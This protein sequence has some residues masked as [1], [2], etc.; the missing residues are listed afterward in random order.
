MSV[1]KFNISP[2]EGNLPIRLN[3]WVPLVETLDDLLSVGKWTGSLSVMFYPENDGYLHVVALSEKPSV[4]LDEATLTTI[5]F[6]EKLS[7]KTC[8]Q[9]GKRGWERSLHYFGTTQFVTLCNGCESEM[10][11][12]ICDQ[13]KNIF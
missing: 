8:C 12:L 2:E 4:T 10:N 9:C 13:I 6:L 11:N 7:E 1:V 5:L 3:G